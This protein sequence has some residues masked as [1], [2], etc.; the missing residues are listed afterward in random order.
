MN[1]ER[2]RAKAAPVLRIVGGPAHGR[3]YP[4]DGE[5]VVIGRVNGCDVVLPPLYVSKR[6]AA[7]ERR[8]DGYYLQ[9]L[10]GAAGTFVGGRK[11][12]GPVRLEDGATFRVCDF[13]FAFHEDLDLIQDHDDTS[14]IVARLDAGASAPM[15]PA[16]DPEPTLRAVLRIVGDLGRAL[17][18]DEVLDRSLGG[19]FEIFPRAERG[20]V[21]LK[22]E[23]DDDL[24]VLCLSRP[25]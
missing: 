4:L 12:A 9:D 17:R 15:R 7:I 19:L 5:R 16:V 20:A 14:T 2:T 22:G 13:V 25:D 11:L 10:D 6:H 18:L 23:P 3:L 1:A 21:L 8:P 24:T